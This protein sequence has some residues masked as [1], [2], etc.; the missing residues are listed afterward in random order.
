[1]LLKFCENEQTA[2]VSKRVAPA[3]PRRQ[4][5]LDTEKR[6]CEIGIRIMI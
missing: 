3:R 6:I 5:E 2:D 4:W 1:M